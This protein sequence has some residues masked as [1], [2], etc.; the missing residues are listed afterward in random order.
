MKNI[1]L[2]DGYILDYATNKP[3]DIRKPEEKVRQEYE[4]ILHE[5]YHYEKTQ[6]DIEVPI[7]WGCDKKSGKAD[8][9]IYKTSNTANRNPH[10][11]ILCIVETKRPHRKEG[12]DQLKSYMLATSCDFGVW[13]NGEEIEYVLKDQGSALSNVIYQIPK[14]G[15]KITDLGRMTKKSLEPA[16]NLKTIFRRIHRT[17]YS[18]TNISRKEKLGSELTRLIF[19]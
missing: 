18:N 8:I 2:K 4:K 9:V 5:N 15:E 16:R 10:K 7:Q 11:D 19:N 3:V 6:M 12:I 13:T 1:N 17:L 14:N